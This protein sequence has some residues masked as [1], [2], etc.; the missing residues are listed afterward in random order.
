M[1][2]NWPNDADSVLR[3]LFP[4]LVQGAA[5]GRGAANMWDSLRQGAYNWAQGV[6][7]ITNPVPA[8]EAATQAKAAELIGHVTIMDMNRYTKMAGEFLR[9]KANLAAQGLDE[10]IMGTSIFNPEWS[11]TGDNPAVPTRYRVRVLRNITVRGFTHIE[12]NEWASY[13]IASPITSMAD[14][15]AQANA[16]FSQADYNSRAD[17][18]EILDYQIEVV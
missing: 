7:H 13:E 8:N 3:G 6:L 12:R 9:A 10:Q 15:L 11:T 18:N 5:N 4:S 1:A 17:I 14:V 2:S 16:M